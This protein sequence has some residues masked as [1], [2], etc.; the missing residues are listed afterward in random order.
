MRHPFLSPTVAMI[1]GLS[2]VTPRPA[3]AQQ[4][5]DPT[6][7]PQVA[8][9]GRLLEGGA[10][11]TGA[12]VFV[13]S[14]L[15]SAR[16][17]LWNSGN[18]TLTVDAGL[19]AVVLGSTGMTPIPAAVLAKNG[20]LLHVTIGG[21]PL[22]PDVDI[23]PAFQARSA[24]E[25]VGAFSGDVSGT[26]NQTMVMKLQGLPLDLTTTPPTA[27]QA[28]V[29]NGS[30]WVPGTVA[31]DQG[32]AGPVG[33]QG[34]TGATGPQGLIGMTGAAGSQGPIGLTGLTGAQGLTGPG[35]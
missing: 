34:P 20:L 8:Y 35:A 5:V 3:M 30:Q 28:L 1:I 9:Q 33:P 25:L 13:F 18:Q 14:I 12:R 2:V 22:A 26:Q 24:W 31:G 4:A 10:P 21:T 6:P 27:G 32:P 19:Y 23:L 29:F 17:E 11:I 15:D 7:L 16:N